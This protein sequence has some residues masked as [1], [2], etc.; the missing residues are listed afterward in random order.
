MN[1]V[2]L[3][4]QHNV[5]IADGGASAIALAMQ[6]ETLESVLTEASTSQL[7]LETIWGRGLFSHWGCGVV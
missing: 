5:A 2:L 3:R 4:T 7:E 6:A 1:V